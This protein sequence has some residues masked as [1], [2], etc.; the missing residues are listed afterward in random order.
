MKGF[1]YDRYKNKYFRKQIIPTKPY[2]MNKRNAHKHPKYE[3]YSDK[4]VEYSKGN[5]EKRVRLK[6]S[7][8]KLVYLEN[9]Y[10]KNR[11]PDVFIK[12]NAASFISIP[13][14]NVTIWFQNRR[15]K[16]KKSARC[17]NWRTL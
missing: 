5:I 1:D 2:P 6:Y 12:R 14:K 11:Y 9:I 10:R 16:D 8:D 17:G 13:V 4:I 3:D 15:N 7:H